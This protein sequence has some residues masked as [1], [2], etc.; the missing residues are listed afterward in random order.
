[1]SCLTS[2]TEQVWRRSRGGWRETT[3][4]CTVVL[5]SQADCEGG[6]KKK[7]QHVWQWEKWMTWRSLSVWRCVDFCWGLFKKESRWRFVDACLT[8]TG[9]ESKRHSP[10]EQQHQQHCVCETTTRVVVMNINNDNNGISLPNIL[11][12]L[13][14]SPLLSKVLSFCIW[15]DIAFTILWRWSSPHFLSRIRLFRSSVVTT[16]V[17]QLIL[18]LSLYFS[19][20][21][22]LFL[23]KQNIKS[24][25]DAGKRRIRCVSELCCLNF[26]RSLFQ[27]KLRI[28]S[29]M[30]SCLVV[31]EQ[32]PT[33][34]TS[35]DFLMRKRD[36]DSLPQAFQVDGKTRKKRLPWMEGRMEK[37]MWCGS[38]FQIRRETWRETSRRWWCTDEGLCLPS[39]EWK[40]L[41]SSISSLCQREKH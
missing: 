10:R 31:Q 17:V 26:I 12:W 15:Q 19:F 9:R 22:P 35:C 37:K 13:T 4:W 28:K 16:L 33:K 20:V 32:E 14:L 18:S 36:K 27:R 39:M 21:D 23:N 11:F 29:M 25:V 5:T 34:K 30:R 40:C 6:C 3:N 8:V 7:R 24:L 41:S 1:M 38:F 2:W